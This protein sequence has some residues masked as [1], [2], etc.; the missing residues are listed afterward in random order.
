MND[1]AG[2]ARP[3]AVCVLHIGKT[4]GTAV[5]GM[6]EEHL[7]AHPDAPIELFAHDM[8]LA[9][10]KTERPDCR[11]V[12]FVREPVER[13][14]SGFNSRL[15][16]GQ[17]RYLSEWT[18]EEAR[19]FD[20]FRTPNALGLALSSNSR[21]EKDAAE[22]AMR[23]I[24]HARLGLS[25]YLGGPALLEELQD[26]ILFIGSQ[27]TL[28]DDVAVL[29]GVLGIDPALALPQDDVAAHR[30][31]AGMSRELQPEA[32]A[33]LHRWYAADYQIYAWCLQRRQSLLDK[34]AVDQTG[35]PGAPFWARWRARRRHGRDPK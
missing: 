20:R 33:N 29:R 32:L 19:A 30:S 31:P 13:F 8:T 35:G 11:V 17:P 28:D 7:R 27:T 5:K 4:G 10:L 14:I 1:W 22:D 34:H 2:P 9:R 3:S 16:K 21:E 15:R 26:R 24:T 23:A 25:H 6:L 18:P 12:F